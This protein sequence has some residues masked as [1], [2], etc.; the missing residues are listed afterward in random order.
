MKDPELK[1]TGDADAKSKTLQAWA[2][3]W[4]GYAYSRI[5]SLYLSGVINNAPANGTT[6]D[7]FVDHNAII[8]EANKNFDTCIGILQTVPNSEAYQTMMRT[9]VPSIFYNGIATNNLPNGDISP[10]MWVRQIYTYEARN[11]LANKRVKDMTPADWAQLA[12][13]TDKGLRQDDNI[14]VYS[15]DPNLV[16]DLNGQFQGNGSPYTWFGDGNQSL[17][18][19]ERLIQDFKEG[20]N[21]FTRGFYL[22]DTT[23]TPYNVNIRG[24]GIQFGSRYNPVSIE[25]GGL[26]ATNNNSGIINIACSWDENAL[27]AAEAKIYSGDIEAGLA[28][29]DAVRDGQDAGLAH[30]A[31]TGLLLPE[32][33]EELRKERRIG[34]FLR[35]LAFFDAR[36]WGVIDPVSEGGG[37][38]NAIVLVP[39]DELDL[40]PGS[41]AQALPCL[42]D[43]RYMSY[44][45][46]PQNE[47]DFNAPAAGSAA[48]KN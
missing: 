22:I 46:V 48:V 20:D 6:S 18:T 11:L 21:R 12:S 2:Y 8:A 31:G 17:F 40:P 15:L 37:R 29:I 44:W 41:P 14:F 43:Y 19:S 47:L 34:L 26:Y 25:D 13:L 4:K 7:L 24:R 10:D 39:P 27:M 32:A 45:D 42:M 30:V 5:G 36:R 33:L 23:T 38:A 1:F 16:N 3:W 35:G 9:I 28:L